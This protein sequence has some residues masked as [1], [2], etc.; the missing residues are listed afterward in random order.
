MIKLT[1]VSKIY[2]GNKEVSAVS[3]ISFEV[4]KGEFF[5]L[6]GPSGC[7]K[8]T[9]LKMIAG[10][11]KPTTGTVEIQEKV[12]MVFQSGGLFPWLTVRDNVEFGMKMQKFHK[13][14]IEENAHKYL[15]LVELKGLSGKYPRELSGGQKQR[16]GLARAL[17]TEPEVLLLDEPFSALDPKTTAEL[18]DYLLSIWTQTQ[19]T[20][21]MVSHLLAEAVLLSD[22]IGIMNKGCLVRILEIPLPR[23][24][25]EEQMGSIELIDKIR[26]EFD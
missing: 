12:S 17:A 22:R 24:R 26:K 23:P 2:K 9:I 13:S 4:E 8:S 25:K 20:I 18:H 14:K 16:V 1:D 6:V 10:I 7:G 5:C 3:G 21:V 11:E 15:E 19:K